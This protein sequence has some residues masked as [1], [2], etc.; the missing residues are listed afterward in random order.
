VNSGIRRVGG[1]I[2]VLFL[3]MVAQL[4]Y[5]QVSRSDKLDADG[6]NPR[7]FL[8]NLQRDRGPIVT[9]DGMVV[10]RSEPSKDNFK[11][12]RVYPAETAELFAGIVGYQS[13]QFGEVGVERTFSD[14]LAGRTFS[15]DLRNL[16]DRFATRRPTGTV[17]LTTSSTAQQ[18]ARA[19]LA[20]RK[21]SVVVLDVRTGGVV[22]AYSNPTYNPNLIATHSAKKAS[23]ARKLLLGDPA[24]PLLP[25]A[26]AEVYAPGSTFK[27]V[28]ASLAI[29]NNVDIDRQFPVVRQ[30]P[31]PQ[32]AGQT[33]QNFG[34][35]ACG[36]AMRDGFIVSCNTTF[37]QIGFDLGELL[38]TGVQNF[39]VETD[40]PP[41][42]EITGFDPPIARSRGPKI[43]TFSRN[44]PGFMQ[45]AI[46]QHDVAVTPLEMALVA[47][48]VA[49][50]GSILEPHVVDCVMDPDD[51]VVR[52]VDAGEYKRAM[53]TTTADT[54][55]DFMRAVVDD[56]RGTGS[57]ARIPGIA[58]AGKTGTA[59][60][61]GPPHAWF[62]AFAPADQP[63]YAVSVLVEHGGTDGTNAEATGGRV[64]APIAKQVL[65]AL[66]ATPQQA[67]RCDGGQPGSGGN[68]G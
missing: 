30:I 58:V 1:L 22:A 26:W 66:L 9:A 19:G 38:A 49:T 37:A 34:G 51:R 15:L 54:M 20:G 56:P 42:G 13:V 36:G 29:Q 32:T 21:G 10:A 62:I 46:G 65:E 59:E 14:D 3:L 18:L 27:T 61:G 44:Q 53:D 60:T 40:P 7:G 11:L 57:A 8:R 23:R 12:R 67:S 63:R 16:A 45:D 35:E 43:G 5:V 31:L 48:S 47:E 50:G 4:T 33:L 64:A 39:G 28:T 25:H 6:R 24:Q 68:G 55:R 2:I 41:S 52:Q 17:V